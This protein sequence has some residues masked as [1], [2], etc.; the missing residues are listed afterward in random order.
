ML[1]ALGGAAFWSVGCILG[2]FHIYVPAVWVGLGLLP[3]HAHVRSCYRCAR[4]YAAACGRATPRNVP[5][6]C[7]ELTAVMLHCVYITETRILAMS[8]PA[9]AACTVVPV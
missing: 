5:A 7:Q 9:V 3:M 8:Q 2:W 6:S 1:V 4:S